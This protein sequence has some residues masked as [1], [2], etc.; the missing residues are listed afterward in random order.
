MQ[1]P[2]TLPREKTIVPS[3]A[4]LAWLK[5]TRTPEYLEPASPL[6]HLELFDGQQLFAPTGKSLIKRL[7]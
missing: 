7:E 2:N 4:F 6:L 5:T 3:S 1:S